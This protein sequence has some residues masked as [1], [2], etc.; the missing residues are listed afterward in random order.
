MHPHALPLGRRQLGGLRPDLVGHADPPDVVEVAGSAYRGRVG[1]RETELHRGRLGERGHVAGVPERE[2]ALEVD[3]V[4][5]RGQQDVESGFLQ[6]DV[7]I[8]NDRQRLLPRVVAGRREERV[9]IGQVRVDDGRVELPAAPAAHHRH[10]SLRPVQAVMHLGHVGELG[11][12]HL[13]RDVATRHAFR[14]SA[15]VEPLEGVRQRP[16]H[17]GVETDVPAQRGRRGAVGVDEGGEPAARVT[18]QRGHHPHPLADRFAACDI[19]DQEAQVRQP[20]PVDEIRLAAHRD[21]VA[22]PARV[23]V[24]VGVTADPHEQRRVVDRGLL[25]AGETKSVG[26]AAGHHRRAQHVLGG[27]TETEVDRHREP[28]EHLDSSRQPCGNGHV[29]I[30][31]PAGSVGR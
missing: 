31:A 23:F 17:F 19:A 13:D 26:Q 10:G 9:R 7:V 2:R 3:E 5:D 1:G 11:H 8:R 21:V 15:P 25:L 18:H 14:K 30:V 6:R 24:R 28:G 20:R 12:P 16:L 4:A 22:E 27:L 29:P